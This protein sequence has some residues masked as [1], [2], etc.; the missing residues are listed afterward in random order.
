MVATP[1]RP[2]TWGACRFCGVAVAAGALR[3][4]ICGADR[5]VTA[6]EL[7]RA[8]KSVRRR[9]QLTGI[10]RSLIVIGVVVTITYA[11]VSAVIAGPPV[12]TGDPLTTS[13]TYLVNPGNYTVIWGEITGG[14]YV[15]GNFSSVTPAGTNIA[16]LV[17]NT[18]EWMA[19]EHGAPAVAAWSLAAT[20]DGR[21]VY[22]A[23]VTDN[24]YF[25]F[26]NPYPASSHLAIAVYITTQYESNVAGSGF[27]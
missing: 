9:I 21:I 17:Y 16:L 12:L 25:V 7:P 4:E 5:P 10:L 2:G 19:F 8:S 1:A 11:I 14:D 26:T 3:C 6:S 27:A 24:Y 22:S 18:S 13:G 15:I 20:P 23:P